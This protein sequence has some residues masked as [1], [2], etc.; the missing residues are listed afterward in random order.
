VRIH[1]RAPVFT[2]A[3]GEVL[4]AEGLRIIPSLPRTPR[5]NAT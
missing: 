2:A 4:K 5:M 3:L 1:D